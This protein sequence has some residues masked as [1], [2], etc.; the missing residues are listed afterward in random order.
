MSKNSEKGRRGELA[1]TGIFSN[2]GVREKKFEVLRTSET[3]VADDGVDIIVKCP[4]NTAEKF[5]EIVDKGSSDIA[6]SSTQIGVRV[7][8]KN[9]SKPITKAV[10]EGFVEDIEKNSDFDEHWLIGGTRLT[11]GAK[12]E[13]DKSKNKAPIR[14]YSNEGF[15]KIQSQY[16][17][18]PFSEINDID[19]DESK[20]E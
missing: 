4:H 1:A 15:T 3:T 6:L 2:I 9:Y 13:L 18:I 8:V 16:P 19:D 11:K 20:P 10:A 12:E 17:A 5:N 14:Y 7:Q